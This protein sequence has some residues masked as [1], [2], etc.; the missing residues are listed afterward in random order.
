MSDPIRLFIFGLGYTASAFARAM[1]G[2]AAS[3]AGTVRSEAK[4]AALAGE[5][6]N[7]MAFDG[8]S[9]STAVV[10]ALQ[11]ATHILV[12]IPPGEDGEPV[13]A[14]HRADIVAATDLAWIGYLST[15]GV[16]GRYGGAWVSERTTPHPVHGRSTRRLAAERAW[17]GLGMERGVP[18]GVFRL[19]GIYGPG[20]NPFVKLAAGDAHRIVKPGQVFNRIH[21]DDIVAALAAALSGKAA[22]VYNLTDDEPAPPQDVV[23]LAAFLMGA[24]PPPEIPFEKA[25]LSPLARSFYDDNK[26][27]LNRRL[28]EALG[29]KLRY[30]TYREGLAALW[31]DGAWRG[32]RP[33]PG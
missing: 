11:G 14:H 8:I 28:K 23:T 12:S 25:D 15:V 29:V 31:R 7:A 19:A 27:V 2:H 13:L 3:V 10:R 20:R 26:R 33:I 18:V 1:Q 5:G 16:Y 17:Q 30:P 24:P 21:L 22:G 32:D 4:A 9:P 6:I